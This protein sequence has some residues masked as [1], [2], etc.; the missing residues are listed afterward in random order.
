MSLTT[1]QAFENRL[2][3]PAFLFAAFLVITQ[4]ALWD[5]QSSKR[6]ARRNMFFG[7]RVDPEF[8]ASNIGVAIHRR[9]RQ[10]IWLWSLAVVI[11]YSFFPWQPSDTPRDLMTVVLP[12][13]LASAGNL[14]MF[15]LASRETAKL[16]I[17]SLEPPT[18]TASLFVE[19]E[20]SNAWLTALDWFVILLPIGLP[21]ATISV[22][23]LHWNTFPKGYSAQH[24]LT[25]AIQAALFGVLPAGIYLALRFGARSSDWAPTPQASRRYRT[26]LGL[27]LWSVFSLQVVQMC[28][29]ALIPFLGGR[30]FQ[31]LLPF[32]RYSSRASLALLPLLGI[33][34]LYLRKKLARG[35]SDPMPDRYWKLGMFYH[36]AA[37]P[38]AVVP[39]RSGIGFAV[40]SANRSVWFI[41]A[42][43][44]ATILVCLSSVL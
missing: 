41:G 22:I 31:Y 34:Q 35:S 29:L 21:L 5:W 16:A 2:T 44:I 17:L 36:N 24:E 38:A 9:F 7:T 27:M 20:E 3:S 37:D 6:L 19:Q 8:I 18:R 26:V 4:T 14:L 10:R 30:P 1:L 13:L 33:A 40:N 23:A 25:T 43:G 42:I 11:A 32:M 15:A 39:G 28:G 12:P